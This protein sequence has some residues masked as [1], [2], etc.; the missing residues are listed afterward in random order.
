MAFMAYSPELSCAS[1]ARKISLSMPAATAMEG[2]R[3]YSTKDSHDMNGLSLSSTSIENLF[4]YI[5]ACT[6]T[7]RRGV[8]NLKV[9]IRCIGY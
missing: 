1:T 5:Q 3:V 9:A 2:S 4:V 7:N 6:E 8:K